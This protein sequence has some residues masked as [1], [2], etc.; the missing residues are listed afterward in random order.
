M[1]SSSNFRGLGI[2]E[3]HKSIYKLNVK[4]T[5]STAILNTLLNCV[6]Q[7]PA[8]QNTGNRDTTALLS[9]VSGFVQKVSAGVAEE[10][11][12]SCSYSHV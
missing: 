2:W 7:Y 1:L 9:V 8:T 5:I 11:K 3:Q 4:K 12:C 6:S 10:K